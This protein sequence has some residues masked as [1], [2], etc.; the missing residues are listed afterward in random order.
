MRRRGT[1]ALIQLELMSPLR[2][3]ENQTAKERQSLECVCF[4]RQDIPEYVD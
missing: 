4:L 2:V 3:C 1:N